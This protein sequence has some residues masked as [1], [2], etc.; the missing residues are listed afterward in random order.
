MKIKLLSLLIVGVAFH[1][2]VNA[3]QPFSNTLTGDWQGNRSG[4][5][6]QGVSINAEY[7]NIYQARVDSGLNDSELT[8]RFDLFAGV[9]TEKL[10]LWSNGS[11]HTQMVYLNGDANDLGITSLSVPNAAH[12]ASSDN[13]FFSSF[14]YNHQFAPT[15]NVMIGKIDAFEMLRHAPFYGGAVRHGFLNVAFS[16]PPSGVTPPAFAGIVANHVIGS[17]R[18]T[19]MVYDP[20]D[21]YTSNLDMSGLFEDGVNT[22]IAATHALKV[23]D[24]SSTFGVSATYSTE[25]GLDFSDPLSSTLAKG[26]YNVRVQAS[27]NVFESGSD[28]IGMYMRAAWADGNPNIIQ[29]TFSTGLSG[30]AFFIDR[31][32]DNWGLGYYHYNLSNSLQE[33]VEALPIDDKLENE[34]GVEMYYAYQAQPWLTFTLDAQYVTSAITTQDNAFLVG[35]RTNIVF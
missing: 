29:G 17:T 6:D 21:R 19:G 9:D 16:A 14:Y 26:K 28:S 4:L 2:A 11:F 7:T 8:H 12:Y 27:H 30:N 13:P 23:F 24:R 22:A 35:L 20:R 31:P 3:E 15:S 1:P 5:V 25:E 34:Q 33:S 32:Q 18:F 10:G